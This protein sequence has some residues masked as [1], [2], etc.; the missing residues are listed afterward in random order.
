[1]K[2]VAMGKP[3]SK[4]AWTKAIRAVHPEVMRHVLDRLNELRAQNTDLR[5]V[6]KLTALLHENEKQ[7]QEMLNAITDAQ[8]RIWKLDQATK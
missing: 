3:L 1:V 2:G 4:R 6:I 7:H 5:T 8:L